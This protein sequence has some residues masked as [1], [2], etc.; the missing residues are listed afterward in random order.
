[1]GHLRVDEDGA[2]VTVTID[3]PEQHNAITFAMWRE[4]G[5]ILED[6]AREARRYDGLRVVILRG[7]GGRA[8]LEKRA[9]RF[10]RPAPPREGD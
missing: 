5:S 2:V 7:E 9:P 8:F 6:L 3:R 10:R 4:L 1:M